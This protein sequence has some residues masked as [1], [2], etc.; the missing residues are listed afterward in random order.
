M[1]GK[2]V[3]IIQ[4]WV[5]RFRPQPPRNKHGID[6]FDWFPTEGE[7]TAPNGDSSEEIPSDPRTNTSLPADPSPTQPVAIYTTLAFYGLVLSAYGA[8]ISKLT[9]NRD[10]AQ[11]DVPIDRDTGPKA[12]RRH[13]GRRSSADIKSS[14]SEDRRQIKPPVIRRPEIIC[15][16]AHGSLQWELALSADDA[17][18]VNTVEQDSESLDL[19][20]G[21]CCLSSFAGSLTIAF[22]D[23]GSTRFPLF[24]GKPLI[25]KLRKNWQGEGRKV[26][27]IM[28]GH[29]IVIAPREWKRTG[30]VPVE[31]EGCR[32]ADFVAH[33]FYRSKGGPVGDPGGFV[34]HDLPLVRSGFELSGVRVFDDSDEGELFVGT[35]P[36]LNP[37]SAVVWA[38]IGEEKKDGW[39]GKNFKPAKRSLAEVLNDRQGR[40][41]VRVYDRQ[42]KRLDSGE[43]RY[44]RDLQ[45]IR[46]NG[47][48]YTENTL[49]VP[50][51]TGHS[52][53]DVQF[54]SSDGRII[55]PSLK[56]D[57]THA[58]VKPN[59]TVVVTPHPDGDRMSCTLD[60]GAGSVDTI[61]RLPLIW[62]RIGQEHGES[63]EWRDTPP[64]MTRKEFRKHANADVTVQLR[65]PPRIN[66]VSVGFDQELDRT[67]RPSKKTGDTEIGL[68]DFLDY[69][70]I[71]QRLNDDASL[72]VHL[73]EG[74][75]VLTLVRVSADPV[76]TIV[77]FR[78][79]PTAVVAGETATLRWITR[80]AESNSVAIAGIGPVGPIGSM[81]VEPT[82]TTT[83]TLRLTSP[84][85]DA[86]KKD[87]TV[88]VRSLPRT[89]RKRNR[90]IGRVVSASMT[91]GIVVAVDRLVAHPLYKK[92]IR[93]TS[94]LMAHDEENACRVG[95]KVLIEETR[96]LSKRKRWTLVRVVEKAKE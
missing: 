67:Y 58:A 68:T 80:N 87:V 28:R 74:E 22:A 10:D 52:P 29:F 70:Q 42:E 41:F 43:F 64:V 2:I 16:K 36:K 60:S 11:D 79:K 39:K 35:A 37:A 65:L 18:Q 53:T 83:F 77:S 48:P 20:D 7:S 25:F 9:D 50:A 14:R 32:D 49:L 17:Y 33:Y 93:R 44:L 82:E 21:V 96:P 47:R 45:E 6:Q 63:D 56:T 46:V 76:P 94:K 8:Y 12:P 1:L 3:E 81:S 75:A 66:S 95:D 62:W 89:G 26:R 54:L 27:G 86:V 13:G 38:R 31:P 61:V 34:G 24:E 30:H 57:G 73:G 92:T 90:K 55:L 23:G 40:F 59:G 78:S 51:S 72:N 88:T 71:D 4:Q 15:R 19:L 91:K 69:S 85:M 84:G 5:S